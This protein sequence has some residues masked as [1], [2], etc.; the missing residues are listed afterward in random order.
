[1][2]TVRTNRLKV[3]DVLATTIYS[4]TGAVWLTAGTPINDEKRKQ[5]LID[6][7]ISFVEIKNSELDDALETTSDRDKIEYK[8]NAEDIKA[9]LYTIQSKENKINLNRVLDSSSKLVENFFQKSKMFYRSDEEIGKTLSIYDKAIA[10]AQYAMTLARIVEDYRLKSYLDN[11]NESQ[12]KDFY[13]TVAVAALMHDIGTLC[14]D[15]ETLM[16]VSKS[17]I[18]K[19]IIAKVAEKSMDAALDNDISRGRL[20]DNGIDISDRVELYKKF[21]PLIENKFV[22][23]DEKYVPLYSYGLVKSSETIIEK[24]LPNMIITEAAIIH[25]KDN[26]RHTNSFIDAPY[27]DNKG[28]D[29]DL[30]VVSKIINIASSYDRL[31]RQATEQGRLVNPEEI[32]AAMEKDKDQYDKRYLDM[33]KKNIPPYDIGDIVVMDNGMEGIVVSLRAEAPSKPVVAIKNP[34]YEKSENGQKFFEMDLSKEKVVVLGK[35]PKKE[36]EDKER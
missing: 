19:Q 18:N 5:Q 22:K 1:M 27:V 2:L 29:T 17:G 20:I 13:S 9:G 8:K 28:N 12:L 15:D 30:T 6:K 32:I 16:A 14:K 4:S 26:N 34:N 10:V 7:G 3:G 11:K 24:S 33:F 36:E 25:Q 31:S 35:K 21:Y 23:Y